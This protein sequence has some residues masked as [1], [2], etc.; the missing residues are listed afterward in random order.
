MLMVDLKGSMN[1]KCVDF[2]ESM[3]EKSYHRDQ[4]LMKQ[5]HVK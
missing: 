4:Q 1:C 3:F 2:F 5:L